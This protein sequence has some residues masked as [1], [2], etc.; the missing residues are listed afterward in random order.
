MI[1]PYSGS[2]MTAQNT[3]ECS[4]FL[5]PLPGG[6]KCACPKTDGKSC[7][8]ASVSRCP[9]LCAPYNGSLQSCSN[10]PG[11]TCRFSCDKGYLP[12]GSAT[13][14]CRDNGT[15]SGAETQCNVINCS[16]L[17][18]SQGGPLRMS[19]CGNHYG[20]KC[21]FSCPIGHLLK[22]SSSLTCVTQKGSPSGSWDKPLP[23]CHAVICGPLI[24]PTNVTISPASCLT[25]SRYNQTCIF[26]CQTSRYVLIGCSSRVCSNDGSWTGSNNARCRLS[27]DE[28]K[29]NTEDR[30]PHYQLAC[31]IL[32][33]AVIL[34]LIIFTFIYKKK[35]RGPT[36]ER[37][38]LTT[39]QFTGVAI[40]DRSN[41]GNIHCED[42]KL[43]KVN[44]PRQN[45]K[46]SNVPEVTAGSSTSSILK[47]LGRDNFGIKSK[48]GIFVTVIAV[49]SISR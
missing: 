18:V 4:D 35:L 6:L 34:I 47:E 10:L 27:N 13:R 43:E 33:T 9:Q 24:P 8:N 49:V 44:S 31:G 29:L 7:D 26:S 37:P 39:N 2:N 32:A 41:H 17:M 28:M 25:S 5:L 36:R 30:T 19:S 42:K 15:W 22:G 46:E 11:Q 12:M 3:L 16:K 40:R 14:T 45:S 21:N 23:T 20:A 48:Q 38:P 1:H